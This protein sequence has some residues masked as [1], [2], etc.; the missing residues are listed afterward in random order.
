VS[1]DQSSTHLNELRPKYYDPKRPP[2][3]SKALVKK[4]GMAGKSI[5]LDMIGVVV[6]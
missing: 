2:A 6:K 4:V 3:A 5:T 1:G